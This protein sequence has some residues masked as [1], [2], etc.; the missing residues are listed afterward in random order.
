[1]KLLVKILRVNVLWGSSASVHLYS[2]P[3]RTIGSCRKPNFLAKER[4]LSLVKKVKPGR[5]GIKKI[6]PILGIRGILPSRVPTVKLVVLL[7]LTGSLKAGSLPKAT[8]G[9]G[10]V[11]GILRAWKAR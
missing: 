10:S 6:V 7:V 8:V 5:G 2:S 1:V 4:A 9:V 3:E 11:G